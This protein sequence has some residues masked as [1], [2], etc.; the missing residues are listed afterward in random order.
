MLCSHPLFFKIR[1]V[2]PVTMKILGD[3]VC[4]SFDCIEINPVVHI[5]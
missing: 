5:I 3:R 2:S 4:F 1:A